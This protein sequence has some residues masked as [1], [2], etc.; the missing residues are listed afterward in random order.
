MIGISEYD[1][2]PDLDGV[3]SDYT[4]IIDT[5]VKLYKYKIL[6]KLNDNSVVYSNDMSEIESKNN[7]KQRWSDGDVDQYMKQLRKHLIKNKHDGILLFISSHGDDTGRSH[8][9]TSDSDTHDIMALQAMLKPDGTIYVESETEKE[10]KYLFRIPKIL[11]VD[12]CRGPSKAKITKLS[13]D[14]RESAVISTAIPQ[15]ELSN[16]A[17][18]D[19]NFCTIYA[20]TPG[21]SVSGSTKGGIFSL[22]V[23][24]VFDQKMYVRNHDLNDMILKIRNTTKANSTIKGNLENMTMTVENTS[25]M[26]KKV[27]FDI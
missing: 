27:Y 3:T 23:C 20:T 2:L 26:E 4:N 9:K 11:F 19:S 7:F 25:T 12:M 5:F 13:D 22:S 16:Y 24:Q 10:S 1:E 8:L 6:Y 18:Q 14:D 21:Y 17:S 15:N